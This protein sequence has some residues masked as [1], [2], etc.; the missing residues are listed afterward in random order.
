MTSPVAPYARS[1]DS[2]Y[3]ALL[4]QER[5][6]IGNVDRARRQVLAHNADVARRAIANLHSMSGLT[7][8]EVVKLLAGDG[9]AHPPKLTAEEVKQ[10]VALE[11]R[12]EEAA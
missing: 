1:A 2:S 8:K 9:F 7:W 4:S 5:S 10:P 11:G 6:G 12:G 3:Q